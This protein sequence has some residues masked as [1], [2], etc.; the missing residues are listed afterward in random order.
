[1]FWGFILL[2]VFIS[3]VQHNADYD[4]Y[5]NRKDVLL[6]NVLNLLCVSAR[7]M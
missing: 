5:D 1:M 6:G 7:C 3:Y 4:N 2:A